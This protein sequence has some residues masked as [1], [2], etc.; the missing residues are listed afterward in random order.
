MNESSLLRRHDDEGL[1]L[2]ITLSEK[3]ANLQKV[4]D[5]QKECPCDTHDLRIGNLEKAVW[6][7]FAAVGLL[8]MHLGYEI[9]SIVLGTG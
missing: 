8:I 1:K 7:I 3:V 5:K 2:L 4:I 9:I 6:V